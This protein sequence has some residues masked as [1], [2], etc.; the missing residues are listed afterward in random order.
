MMTEQAEPTSSEL[1]ALLLKLCHLVG[2]Q[3]EDNLHV[4]S[5]SAEELN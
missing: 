5:M 2:P 1:T 3:L 4:P